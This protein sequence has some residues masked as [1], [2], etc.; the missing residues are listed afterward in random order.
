MFTGIIRELGTVVRIEHSPQ[1]ARLEV[2][3]PDGAEPLER[4]ESIAVN[5]VCL[6]ALP[7]DEGAFAADLS[8]ETLR[9]T[10][11]GDLV[12][13]TRVNLERALALGDRLGGH[14]VQGHVDS[15]GTL[16]SIERQ[17]DFA[18]Y[19]WSFP[20][21]FAPLVVE[22]GSVAVDGISLTVV[23]PDAE[24]FGAALVPETLER[25]G[26]GAARVG[27]RA[28]LEFDVMAKY[29]QNL[30]VHYRSQSDR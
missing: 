12:A 27:D 3:R 18:L 22:K 7:Q 15:T 25:T 30:L 14:I 17:G 11:L 13:G 20:A 10:T 26:L 8:P 5:G 24:T 9:L 28:N 16:I 29:A 4:G 6:T 19:R 23:E 1:G 21:R 2:K